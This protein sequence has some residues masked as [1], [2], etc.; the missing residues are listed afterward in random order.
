MPKTESFHALAH[1]CYK[2]AGFVG[3]VPIGGSARQA[4]CLDS[5]CTWQFNHGLYL[6]NE[7]TFFRGVIY[8]G[9][10]KTKEVDG[11]YNNFRRSV[12]PVWWENVSYWGKRQTCMGANGSWGNI[13]ISHLFREWICEYYEYDKSDHVFFPT[14][15][16]GDPIVPPADGK[17]YTHC[18]KPIKFDAQ[19]RWIYQRCIEPPVW[20]VE[21]CITLGITIAVF[22]LIILVIIVIRCV[23]RRR[24][25]Q[26]MEKLLTTGLENPA[27]IPTQSQINMAGSMFINDMDQ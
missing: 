13:E 22:V 20:Y 23:R 26:K 15:P 25:E 21:L 24:K 11:V 18:G 5:N 19:I 1:E 10:D 8:K 7:L 17:T 3:L 16:D 12:S 2:T 6:H 4:A 14:Y 27:R 9:V